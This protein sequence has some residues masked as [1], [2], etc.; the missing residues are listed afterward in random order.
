M[1]KNATVDE[2]PHTL[3]LNEARPRTRTTPTLSQDPTT[4]PLQFPGY[5]Y[6]NTNPYA[7]P[8]PPPILPPYYG[9]PNPFFPTGFP[10]PNPAPAPQL[11]P[12]A[13]VEYPDVV[14][15]FHYVD[16]HPSR[17][18]DNIRFSPHGPILKNKGFLWLLQLTMDLVTLKDIQELLGIE[19]GMAAL[20][21]LYAREDVNVIKAGALIIPNNADS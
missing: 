6:M 1:A 12:L 19:V 18:K 5:P 11:A 3:H 20:I 8:A 4:Q 13:N 14:S 9:Y 10:G 2:K 16:Q 17:N 15:W 21:K 7:M